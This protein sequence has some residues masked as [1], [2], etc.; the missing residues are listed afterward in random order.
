MKLIGIG[1][2]RPPIQLTSYVDRANPS[3]VNRNAMQRWFF[4]P[5]YKC[6]RTTDDHAAMELVGDGVKLVGA[7][8]VGGD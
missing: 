1:L 2:E 3:A 5:D 7:D 8:E 6:V 4:V